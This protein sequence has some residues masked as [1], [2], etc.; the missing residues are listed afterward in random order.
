MG[1]LTF[2][3]VVSLIVGVMFLFFPQ[4]IRKM[5]DEMNK[6]LLNLDQ[7]LFEMRVGLGISLILVSAMAFFVI[8]YLKKKYGL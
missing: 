6:M 4:T 8:Y 1:F 3:G 5:S 7:R 2:A